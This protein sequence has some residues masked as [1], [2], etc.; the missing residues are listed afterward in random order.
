LESK[1]CDEDEPV[2]EDPIIVEVTED[3][4][5]VVP[6][7]AACVVVTTE[8]ASVVAPPVEPAKIVWMANVLPLESTS[9]CWMYETVCTTSVTI[10]WISV[11]VCRLIL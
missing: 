4:V 11:S 1:D 6:G 2:W 7:L 3:A 5:L 9:I 8:D 10:C